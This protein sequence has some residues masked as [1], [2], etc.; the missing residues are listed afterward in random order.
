[1]MDVI[2]ITFSKVGEQLVQQERHF[3][4]GYEQRLDNGNFVFTIN[5]KSD[6]YCINLETWTQERFW[7]MGKPMPFAVW[8]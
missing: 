2:F 7:T 4:D 6:H 3:A 8:R 5:V 1:M